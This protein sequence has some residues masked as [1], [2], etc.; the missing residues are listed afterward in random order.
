V[1]AVAFALSGIDDDLA[2]HAP[3]RPAPRD[4]GEVREIVRRAV[5]QGTDAGGLGREDLIAA[6]RDVGIAPEA[7]DTAS[8]ELETEHELS[9]EV[10][11]LQPRECKPSCC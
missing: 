8:A 9:E 2:N 4:G 6:A 11:K 7:G 5:A 10:A 1:Q 3:A